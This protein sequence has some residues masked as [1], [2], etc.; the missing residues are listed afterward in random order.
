M[1]KRQGQVAHDPQPSRSVDHSR[2]ALTVVLSLAPSGGLLRQLMRSRRLWAPAPGDPG[3][4]AGGG[5]YQAGTLGGHWG[6]LG[7]AGSIGG[8]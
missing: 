1:E 3:H 6:T 8:N 7:R 2:C 5:S 4:S